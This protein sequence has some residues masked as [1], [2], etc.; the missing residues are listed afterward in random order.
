MLTHIHHS[1]PPTPFNKWL[2]KRLQLYVQHQTI[3]L[4]PMLEEIT[5]IPPWNALQIISGLARLYGTGSICHPHLPSIE[6][7]QK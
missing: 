1:S 2:F 4:L 5:P 6:E 7:K 3:S